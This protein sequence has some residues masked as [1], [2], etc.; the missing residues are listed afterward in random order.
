MSQP[1]GDWSREDRAGAYQ[2]HL[3]RVSRSFAFCIAEL[4]GAFKFYVGHCYLMFRV[5]DTV[6][7]APWTDKAA[8]VRAFEE[9]GSFLKTMPTEERLQAWSGELLKLEL[10]QGEKDLLKD[11][12]GLFYDFHFHLEEDIQATVR[13]CIENMSRGMEFYAQATKEVRLK[14]LADVNRYCFFVA[15]VVGELL[16]AIF[17]KLYPR[18]KNAAPEDLGNALHFGLFLQ[19]V[20]L[21][22]DQ[23]K[24]EKEGRFLVP[25]RGAVQQ[26]LLQ[27]ARKALAYLKSLP[28]E[29]S[30]YRVFCAWSLFLG[31]AS[32]PWIEKSWNKKDPEL[33]IPRLRT[34]MLLDK[35]AKKAQCN[36]SLTELFEELKPTLSEPGEKLPQDGGTF[37]EFPSLYQG[38]LSSHQLKSL[39]LISL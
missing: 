2:K 30:K 8:Q 9:F 7:D 18:A 27:N 6:E 1:V 37:K 5:L 10:P 3:N 24:D 26:S 28:E 35:V 19:K 31:L 23:F 33:K 21:L 14:T 25:S 4:E 13:R 11:T 22:K 38:S 16:H 36:R 39:G 32:L 17:L 34:K 20:N 15:G 12:F 29:A